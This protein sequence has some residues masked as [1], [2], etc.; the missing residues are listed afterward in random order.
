M[1]NEFKKV[2]LEELKN[3]AGGVEGM[4]GL[5]DGPYKTVHGLQSGWL[6]LRSKPCYNANN[7]IGKLYNG[8]KVK[9]C[10]NDAIADH[11]FDKGGVTY[12]TWVYSPDLNKSGWVNSRFI[13]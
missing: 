1:K 11:D 3:I 8:Y 13:R 9:V 4:V 10:G 7:E 12:Y 5:Y 6:A 2:T